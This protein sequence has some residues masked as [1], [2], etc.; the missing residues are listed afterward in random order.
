MTDDIAMLAVNTIGQFATHQPKSDNLT[1]RKL[2]LVL[3]GCYGNLFTSKFSTG[4]IDSN[5]KDKGIRAAMLV[6][7]SAL[8]KYPPEVIE[9]AATRLSTDCPDFPPSLPKFVSICRACM[10]YDRDE[11]LKKINWWRDRGWLET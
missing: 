4:A 5:G 10:P 9:E 3:H 2:F 11:E 1:I 7:E 6:W 8:S